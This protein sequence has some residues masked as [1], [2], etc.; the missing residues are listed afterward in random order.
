MAL[1]HSA[2]QRDQKVNSSSGEA[3]NDGQKTKQEE[4]K[5]RFHYVNVISGRC[6]QRMTWS[7]IPTVSAATTTS[8]CSKILFLSN[9]S[10]T[11]G[12]CLT[13]DIDFFSSCPAH[14]SWPSSCFVFHSS[15]FSSPKFRCHCLILL[16]L[17][18]ISAL[19]CFVFFHFFSSF[20]RNSVVEASEI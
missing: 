10:H 14:S 2:L 13:L 11:L 6:P 19:P 1:W 7:S 18:F 8:F 16:P 15:T 5:S 4:D 17:F 20:S 9:A 12:L 3:L